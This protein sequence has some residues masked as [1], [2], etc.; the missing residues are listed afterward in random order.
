MFTFLF[1][2][3]AFLAGWIMMPRPEWVEPIREG[4][5]N[6]FKSVIDNIRNSSDK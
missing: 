6:W 3:L 2:A 5:V 1:V 4:I